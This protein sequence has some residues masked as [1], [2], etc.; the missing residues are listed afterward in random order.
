MSNV[1]VNAIIALI[2]EDSKK[3]R[4]ILRSSE[5]KMPIGEVQAR[6]FSALRKR[7]AKA[8]IVI[9]KKVLTESIKVE[10]S[11]DQNDKEV[12][13]QGVTRVEAIIDGF[14]ES[15]SADILPRQDTDYTVSR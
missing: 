10:P 15:L 12:Y 8:Q 5:L 13:F 11:A 2:E 4:E 14:V 9:L 1:L 7:D 3:A 6:L